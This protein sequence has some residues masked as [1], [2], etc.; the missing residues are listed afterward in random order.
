MKLLIAHGSKHHA[1]AEIAEKI[2]VVMRE[3]GHEVDVLPAQR[4]RDVRKYDA[5]VIGGALYAGMWLRPAQELVL[6]A[7]DDLRKRHSWFF[8]SGPLDDSAKTSVIQPTPMVASLM[9]LVGAHGHATFGGRLEPGASAMAKKHA[10][11]WRDNAQIEAWARSISRELSPALPLPTRFERLPS[12]ALIVSLCLVVGIT[13]VGG[14]ATLMASPDG[15]AMHMPLSQL[16]HSPFSDFM[17]PG[18]ILFS[19]VG[20]GNLVSAWL[21][22]RRFAFAPMVSVV[23][24]LGLTIWIL[25]QMIMLRSVHWLHVGYLV[26]GVLVIRASFSAIAQTF[27]IK[28]TASK[29]DELIHQH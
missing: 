20:L 21:Y 17:V 25:V 14:G 16:E 15:S 28:P 4:V 27:P 26:V 3:E 11:D 8:S 7:R 22:I 6:R 5:V 19:I 2:A 9:K 13:A 12:H 29:H 23:T 18:L 1:T 10:G 24:G